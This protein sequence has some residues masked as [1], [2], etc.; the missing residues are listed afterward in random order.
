VRIT[1]G[2][3]RPLFR[4]LR[5]GCDLVLID[6][7]C[8]DG[9]PE[10]AVLATLADAVYLVAPVAA[11]DSPQAAALLQ[12]MRQQGIPVRGQVLTGQ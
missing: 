4:Q 8:W 11:A 9:R 2:A 12:V 7:P 5:E 10:A 1:A 3:L 6:G